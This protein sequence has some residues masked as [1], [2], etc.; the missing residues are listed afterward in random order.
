MR[1]NKIVLTIVAALL[2]IGIGFF[3]YKFYL[4]KTASP[5]REAVF[6][7][8]GQVY[9]GY[10]ANPSSQIV[11]LSDVYYLKTND[12]QSADTTKKIVLVKMGNELHQPENIMYIN[13]DQI[14]FFQGLTDA[15]KINDAIARFVNQSSTTSSAA[16]TN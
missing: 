15:S 8:N 2:V 7:N 3:G 1:T 6:M 16:T 5:R 4:S 13:R 12:L 14:L 10:I 11:K 9:F